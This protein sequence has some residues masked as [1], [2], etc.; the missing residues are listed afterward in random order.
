MAIKARPINRR[1]SR[2]AK[3]VTVRRKPYTRKTIG[4]FYRSTRNA[5]WSKSSIAGP[6][7]SKLQFAGSSFP[8]NLWTLFNYDT[9]INLD[10]SLAPFVQYRMNSLYDPEV[11][12]GGTQPRYY[13]TLVGADGTN[14]PYHQYRVHGFKIV[15]MVCNTQQ[16]PIAIS[17]TCARSATTY[18]GSLNEAKERTDTIVRY[19]GPQNGSRQLSRLVFKGKIK[20]FLGHKDLMDVD[21]SAAAYNADPSEQVYCT[22]RIWPMDRVSG[23][24][25]VLDSRI[26]YMSQLYQLNDVNDS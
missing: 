8:P 21:A 6:K 26:T 10:T 19:F 16:W 15:S 20:N 13:D 1:G 22:I 5:V 14:A 3:V 18:P 12:T 25:A 17:L 9:H 7:F 11:A 23:V 24:S 4:R 2:L